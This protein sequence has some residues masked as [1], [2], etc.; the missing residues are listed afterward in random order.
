MKCPDCGNEMI[1]GSI[2]SDREVMWLEPGKKPERITSKLF[3]HSS[4][5]AER[6]VTCN[7]VVVRTENS[8]EWA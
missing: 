4:A 1:R 5:Y 3:L 2:R 6:C 7:I 8:G